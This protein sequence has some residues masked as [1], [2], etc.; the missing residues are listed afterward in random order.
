MFSKLYSTKCPTPKIWNLES[1]LRSPRFFRNGE[2][3]C[4]NLGLNE[5]YILL[6]ISAQ[7][8]FLTSTKVLESC[9]FNSLRSIYTYVRQQWTHSNIKFESKRCNNICSKSFHFS[10]VKRQGSRQTTCMTLLVHFMQLHHGHLGIRQINCHFCHCHFTSNLKKSLP[11]G[12]HLR[13]VKIILL[14]PSCFV[15]KK[16]KQIASIQ[17]IFITMNVSI[18]FSLILSKSY[19]NC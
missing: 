16:I 19:R 6:F 13:N 2:S 4:D 10:K 1:H 18:E 12:K 15:N 17:E 9:L 7:R 3:C 8:I 14:S 5:I 11:H